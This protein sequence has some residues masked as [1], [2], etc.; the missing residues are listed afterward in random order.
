MYSLRTQ[1]DSHL[2]LTPS[3][4]QEMLELSQFLLDKHINVMLL[5]ETHLTNKYNFNLRGY[6][7]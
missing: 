7:F 4:P 2:T 5:S 1:L 6:F 3:P